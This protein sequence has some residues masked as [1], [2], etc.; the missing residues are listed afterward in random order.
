[1]ERGIHTPQYKRI[2]KNY[3]VLTSFLE[4]NETAK[5]GLTRKYKAKGW[6]PSHARPSEDELISQV[7]GRIEVSPKVYDEFIA[8]LKEV[9]GTEDIVKVLTGN[10][11]LRKSGES[12][13]LF[14]L[15]L[16]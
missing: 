2:R 16:L 3:D 9:V 1:M 7:M 4:A 5:N 11:P 12:F 6:L 14:S 15:Y 13:V 10:V 8:I